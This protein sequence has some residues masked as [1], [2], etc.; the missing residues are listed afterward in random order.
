MLTYSARG[1]GTLRRPDPLRRRRTTRSHDAKLLVDYLAGAARGAARTAASR[2]SP[3]PARPTAAALSLLLAAADPRVE[4]VVADITWNDL[5]HALFPNGADRARACSRSCGP[6]SCSA[7]RSA[8]GRAIA[9]W[10]ATARR[11]ASGTRRA[12]DGSPPTCA[13]PTRRR[14]RP[15]RPTAGDARADAAGQPGDGHRPDH[16]ADPARPRA[17]RTRCSRSSE[18]DANA[19]GI[20]ANGTPV[21]VVWRAGGHDDADVGGGDGHQRRPSTGSTQVFARHGAD[22]TSRSSSPSRPA[23]C[24][25][26]TGDAAEQI[27]AGRRLPRH[28]RRRPR[29]RRTR[30]CRAAA[31]QPIGAPAGG[32]PAAITSIPGLGGISSRFD[33]RWPV[34]P[35]RAGPDRHVRLADTLPARPADRR[36][37]DACASPSPRHSTGDVDAVRRAARPRPRRHGSTLPV[38]ARH[39]APADR[40]APGRAAHRHRASCRRSCARSCPGTGSR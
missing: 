29:R 2:R 18:A 40:P 21:R 23:S 32:A 3:R 22:G 14:P 4:A 7:T 6:G 24:R 5:S 27:A 10:S 11:P 38:A 34:L 17:S 9:R 26:P 35:P 8:G 30:R 13:P 36:R 1:F 16:R 15:A 20:A 25:R 31:P 39:A 37:A 33:R 19:R 12:A 28:R